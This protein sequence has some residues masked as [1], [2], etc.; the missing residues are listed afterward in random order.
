MQRKSPQKTRRKTNNMYNSQE[1]RMS[2]AEQTLFV[3]RV[4]RTEWISFQRTE[5][6]NAMST[7]MLRQMAAALESA[8][9][10]DA[11]RTIVL[12]GSG[13]AFCAGA[14]L[15]EVAGA[16]HAPGEPDLLD[17]VDHTFGLMRHGPKPVIAAVN[18]LAMA[19]GLEM[20]MAC[21]LV[22]A[23]ES[24]Q[25]GDAH[26]NFGVFPGAGGAAIL[27]RR[28]GLNRAKYLLFSGENVSAQDMMDWG[29]VNKVV[30]DEDL[31]EAVQSFTNR[32]AD[33]SPSVLR[34]MKTV[35]N[36]S[37]DVD[38]TAA[39]TEEMLNLRAHMRSWD[40][41]EGLSAFNEKRK[42]QFRGY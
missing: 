6:L 39:L 1:L 11:V 33:K 23:A 42:P 2:E 28:I 7:Q 5:Q 22:F 20:V 13:R 15:K 21:D 41:H 36:R 4:D 37:L 30:A 18:G 35:A 19:G 34:R 12:T 17:L 24:A 16:K 29:L 26:S 10:D 25:L 40:M 38:E 32:L 14:D 3:E 31:R 8:L 9:A 27:P